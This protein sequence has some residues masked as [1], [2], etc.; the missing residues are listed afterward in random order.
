[1][2]LRMGGVEITGVEQVVAIGQAEPEPNH[3][4]SAVFREGF[5]SLRGQGPDLDDLRII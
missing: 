5:E 2:A 4:G 3:E 1:M